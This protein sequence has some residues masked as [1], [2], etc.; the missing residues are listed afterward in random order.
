[1]FIAYFD[2]S[3]TH[4]ETGASQGSGIVAAAGYVATPAVWT[5]FSADWNAL[6]AEHRLTFYHSAACNAGRTKQF[7]GTDVKTRNQMHRAF[8]EV[9]TRHPLLAVGYAMPKAAFN[10]GYHE[11]IAVQNRIPKPAYFSSLV[12]AWRLL[13]TFASTAA[14]MGLAPSDCQVSI[15]VED[16]PKMHELTM[17]SY[18]VATKSPE[19]EQHRDRFVGAP[20][21]LRKEGNPPL[22]AADVLAYEMALILRR[23][24]IPGEV[25][26]PRKS[27]EALLGHYIAQS[28]KTVD[29]PLVQFATFGLS[30]H[31]DASS[32]AAS[33]WPLVPPSEQ[34]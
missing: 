4:D 6:L 16:S 7:E 29:R 23:I 5:A 24:Y 3:G 34:R 11:A 18:R 9:I 22:Q 14:L 1:M 8:V 10:D 20:E 21:L 17:R 31:P 30:P 2:D 27:W 19:W 12:N 25:P 33:W 13:A 26:R 32:F 28:K 15:V